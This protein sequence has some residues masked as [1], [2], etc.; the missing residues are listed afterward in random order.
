M[1]RM[2]LMWL[3]FVIGITLWYANR[4]VWDQ[5]KLIAGLLQLLGILIG[6]SAIIG[7]WRAHKN[8]EGA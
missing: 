8:R 6:A 1:T 2:A 7:P 4:G 5:T 3:L